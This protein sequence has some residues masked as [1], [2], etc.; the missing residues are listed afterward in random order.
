MKYIKSGVIINEIDSADYGSDSTSYLTGINPA[1]VAVKYGHSHL[2]GLL[3]EYGCDIN[4]SGTLGTSPLL[5]AVANNQIDCIIELLKF[6]VDINIID[7]AGNSALHYATQ[8]KDPMPIIKILADNGAN[9][10][11]TNYLRFTPLKSA[12]AQANG[13]AIEMLGGR[14]GA[15]IAS[16]DDNTKSPRDIKNDSSENKLYPEY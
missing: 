6:D 15:M 3:I 8:L 1:E 10:K 12:Y 9:D 14:R 16:K 5:T 7:S 11:L 4:D 13:Q 2:L